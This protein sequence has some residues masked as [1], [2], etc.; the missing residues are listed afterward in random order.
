MKKNLL[1]SFA[2]LL[3]S[4]VNFAQ[5]SNSGSNTT[6]SSGVYLS[7]ITVNGYGNNLYI[8]NVTAGTRFNTDV[9]VASINNIKKD[10]SY[11]VGS[12]PFN[13][14]PSISLINSGRNNITTP[15]NVAMTVT[16]G[17]Y[18]S[19]KSVPSLNSGVLQEVLFDVLTITPGQAMTISVTTYL[20]GDEYTNNDNL[21]QFSIVYSG[22]QRKVLVEEWTSSTCGPCAANNP[23]V[24]AFISANFTSLAAIKYHVGWPAPGNDPMYLYNPTQ[25]YDR[26]YYYGVNAVP[27]VIMDGVVNPAYPYSTP[28][29]LPD[30]FNSRINIGSPLSVE[31]TDTRLAGDTIQAEIAVTI[32]SPLMYGNYYLRV[33]AIERTIQYATP[34]GSNGETI[35]HDVF[36]RAFPNSTG[37]SIPISLGTHIFT[38]KYPVDMA[39]WVDS[40]IYTAAFVQNDFTKEVINCGKARNYV[41]DFITNPNFVSV[42]DQKPFEIAADIIIKEGAVIS[43]N[44]ERETGNFYYELFESSFPPSGWRVVNPDGGITFQ[45]FSGANGNSFGGSKSVKLDFYSYGTTGQTDTMY[46]GPFDGLLATDSIKFD[47][48]YA[49][50]PGYSDRLIVKASNNGGQTF[51]FTIFDKAGSSLATAPNTTNSFIPNSSQWITFSYSLN[52]IVPVE[53]TSFT[54]SVSDA[55]IFL[56]WITATELNNYGF[57]IQRSFDENDFITVGFVNGNGTSSEQHYYSYT[58]KLELN[59]S[60][61]IYYRLKQVDF[62]G[63]YNYSNVVSIDYEIPVEFTLSQN[64]PN[65]FNP[66]TTIT[67]SVASTSLVKLRVYDISGQE[68]I[69]LVNE[70]KN[71]GIYNI[72]FDASSM[73]SGVYLVRMTAGKFSSI[74]KMNILK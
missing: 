59:K 34:P 25:S 74:V 1:L 62:D 50:Y 37:I 36:R 53:L 67:Y 58:D 24:D 45:Q 33:H 55:G 43:G 5:E 63:K 72:N 64:Y 22:T 49:Q 73:A 32:L 10:T 19:N 31:V 65:P 13:I 56:K 66:S 23:S 2:I 61:K 68:I 21:T 20:P 52:G 44:P 17:S 6:E 38:I 40:M 18:S 46:A 48:A 69:T 41:L 26:R 7:F 47:Y 39:V 12:N 42:S 35:F 28:S 16:P 60:V 15:F 3:S 54:A 70:I 27:H 51:P 9:G 57:E 71:P 8:D 14:I 30:A 4:I 29:S 11:T